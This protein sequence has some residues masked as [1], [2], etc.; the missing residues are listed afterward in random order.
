MACRI[1]FEQSTLNIV[2]R[3]LARLLF[4]LFAGFGL[5]AVAAARLSIVSGV[6]SYTL[7]KVRRRGQTLIPVVGATQSGPI[8]ASEEGTGKEGPGKGSNPNGCY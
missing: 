1:V 5:S 6:A 2:L 7:D 4:V 8:R 3:L